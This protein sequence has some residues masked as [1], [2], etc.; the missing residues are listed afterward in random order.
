MT[1]N[2]WVLWVCGKDEG[3]FAGDFRGFGTVNQ[4]RE[5]TAPLPPWARG[6]ASDAG[7]VKRTEW[8]RCG[9][10]KQCDPWCDTVRCRYPYGE[11]HGNSDEGKP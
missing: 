3:I 11:F 10:G 4:A 2:R 8:L 1:R 7:K 9:T 5:N 6:F